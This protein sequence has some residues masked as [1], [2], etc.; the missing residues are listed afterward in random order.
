MDQNAQRLHVFGHAVCRAGCW[1]T[2][3]QVSAT[4]S[5]LVP[6]PVVVS[7]RFDLVGAKNANQNVTIP[8]P[9]HPH[10]KLKVGY[11]DPWEI[12]TE[13][14][15]LQCVSKPLPSTA[16]GVRRALMYL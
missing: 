7:R 4:G 11:R 5:R 15:V 2:P 12:I 14:T 10:C 8:G 6:C 9:V 1:A 13:G 3:G 16:E